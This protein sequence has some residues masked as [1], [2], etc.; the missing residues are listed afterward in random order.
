METAYLR[1]ISKKKLKEL[2]KLPGHCKDCGRKTT[3][4]L[5]SP[6]KKYGKDIRVYLCR[7]CCKKYGVSESP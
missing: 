5:Y 3:T 7:E 4:K 6:F 1:G 2:K